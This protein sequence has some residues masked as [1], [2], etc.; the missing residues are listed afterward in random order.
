MGS[1][2]SHEKE[3]SDAQHAVDQAALHGLSPSS[4]LMQMRGGAGAGGGS[5]S[6][7][8][9]AHG[10]NTGAGGAGGGPA[11]GVG[12]AGGGGG[13][14]GAAGF[15][16]CIR[17]P[18][19][20]LVIVEP[21]LA[22]LTNYGNTC[23]ANSVLQMLFHTPSFRRHIVTRL[24][25]QTAAA[26][27]ASAGTGPQPTTEEGIAAAKRATAAWKESLWFE[28][29]SL[30]ARMTAAAER[31]SKS[32]GAGGIPGA[33][34][35]STSY[36]SATA[37]QAV[38]VVEPREFIECV[39]R[40]CPMFNNREQ[41]DAHEFALTM[42]NV[43]FDEEA[44]FDGGGSNNN[45]KPG[46]GAGAAA[47]AAASLQSMVG[48]TIT[49]TSC[50]ECDTT[51]SVKEKLV[52]CSCTLESKASLRH[53]AETFTA[54]EMLVGENK[55]RCDACGSSVVAR[56]RTIV[57]SPAPQLLL[58]QVKRFRYTSHGIHKLCD[59][60]PFSDRLRV[61]VYDTA[62]RVI[63]SQLY[64][65]CAFVV[66]AGSYPMAGHYFCIAYHRPTK[67]WLMLN[68]ARAAVITER[69][70]QRYLGTCSDLHSEQAQNVTAYVLAYER[71]DEEDAQ[72]MQRQ[73]ERAR[74]TRHGQQQQQPAT[75][76]GTA[77]NNINTE[78]GGAAII[79]A[80]GSTPAKAKVL[81]Q[82]S[83][84]TPGHLNDAGS[85]MLTSPQM[86]V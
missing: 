26:A 60:I 49:Q 79:A 25:T 24:A 56:R 2:P 46:R 53:V 29:A 43:L 70:R 1:G 7:T 44:R 64:R 28:L 31:S 81:Y 52:D 21:S 84:P 23:Y 69:E 33:S 50:V 65:L 4:A 14:G 27:A 71:D 13:G 3:A 19:R 45:A 8:G 68:D 15:V 76:R 12:A 77:T 30:F 67:Q 86:L 32:L 58:L 63:G 42:L 72:Q 75:A 55:F 35:G 74:E 10:G 18:P 57:S 51:T 61:P 66:H 5:S 37:T 83:M 36:I 41:H 17:G 47:T 85:P 78:S 62:N 22:G 39:R 48:T 80:T 34:V 38:P 40:M 20:S 16:A 6:N 59:Y 73:H 11:G 54:Y 82:P 9:T